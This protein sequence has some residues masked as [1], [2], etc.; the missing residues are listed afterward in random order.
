MV[1]SKHTYYMIT[2]YVDQE[3]ILGLGKYHNSNTA[4]VALDPHTHERVAT[5]SINPSIKLKANEF[6]AKNYS[7]CEGFSEWLVAEGIAR[8]TSDSFSFGYASCPIMELLLPMSEFSV[9]QDI[10]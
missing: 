8:M 3:V 10:L 7:E 5:I 2:K 4:L 1:L 9:K 6:I